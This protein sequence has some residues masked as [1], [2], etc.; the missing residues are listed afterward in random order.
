MPLTIVLRRQRQVK[1][2][3][4]ASLIFTEINKEN[5]YMWFSQWIK[6]QTWRPEFDPWN[7]HRW[8][9]ELTA[10]RTFL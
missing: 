10:K 9:G 8:V 7:L 2:E 3:F 6:A 5:L 4:N 1:S